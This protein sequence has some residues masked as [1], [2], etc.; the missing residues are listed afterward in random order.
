MLDHAEDEQGSELPA[1]TGEVGHRP[2]SAA[3]SVAGTH[4][5]R[6]TV[7]GTTFSGTLT[8]YLC[9]PVNTDGC[10]RT[11]GVQVG[12]GQTVSANGPDVSGSATPTPPDATA[13][14][15]T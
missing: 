8:F 7:T 3:V 6:L 12:S 14:R 9:G 15:P 13:G 5:A 11:K 2:T 4:T 1:V 10:D